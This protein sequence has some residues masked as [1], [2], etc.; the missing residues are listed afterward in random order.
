M[1]SGG[2]AAQRRR[3]ACRQRDDVNDAIFSLNWLAGFREP[4]GDTADIGSAPSVL[5]EEVHAR[6]RRRAAALIPDG[7]I[8]LPQT[9]FHELL[10]GRDM[11]HMSSANPNLA[12]FT[13]VANISIPRTCPGR[14][15]WTMCYL[16]DYSRGWMVHYNA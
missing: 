10:R 4:P 8:P 7:V 1:S 9:A 13:S 6:V 15:S 5:Q 16:L 3:R 14:P 2:H 11:Y 12:T